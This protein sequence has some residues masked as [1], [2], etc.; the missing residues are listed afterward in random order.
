MCW[1]VPGRTA[2]SCLPARHANHWFFFC[3]L[4]EALPFLNMKP[5]L[6]CCLSLNACAMECVKQTPCSAG[7]PAS[8]CSRCRDYMESSA[9][10]FLCPL[11]RQLVVPSQTVEKFH[12]FIKVVTLTIPP[13]SCVQISF[14]KRS[15]DD[16][17]HTI[18]PSSL[19]QV[20]STNDYIAPA[21]LVR[22]RT[23]ERA[24]STCTMEV[25]N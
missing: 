16:G 12:W 3:W 15:R 6:S 20:L 11:R 21:R 13:L 24:L 23:G 18:K 2:K 8:S 9:Q 5:V 1:S 19:W 17:T 22:C 10:K 7:A 25:G 14:W 4:C